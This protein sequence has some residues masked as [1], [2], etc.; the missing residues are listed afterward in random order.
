MF[1]NWDVCVSTCKGTFLSPP[2]PADTL[3]QVC[4]PGGAVH[5]VDLQPGCDSDTPEL[6]Q[7]DI[8][9][10]QQLLPSLQLEDRQENAVLPHMHF[11]QSLCTLHRVAGSDRALQSLWLGPDG[12]AGSVLVG[13]VCQLLDSVVA[14][15]RDPPLLGPWD[16]TLKACQLSARATDLFCSQR[17]L[18]VDFMRRVEDSLMELTAMLLHNNQPSKVSHCICMS[19]C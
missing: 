1:T 11:L 19:P 17:L 3:D 18:N 9:F 12:D 4:G 6:L 8:V 2:G 16:L 13:T 5:S 7:Q 14:A 10:S 15:C